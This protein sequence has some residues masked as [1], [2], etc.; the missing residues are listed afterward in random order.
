[1]AR[2]RRDESPGFHH[3]VSRGNN[4]RRIYDDDRDRAFFALHVTRIARA[5]GWRI[6][7]YC[8]MDN[9]YHLVIHVGDKGLSRGMCELNTG[10]AVYYNR[11]HGRV[12]HLFGKRYWNRR[13]KSEKSLLNVIRY[14]V[15]NP[16]RAGGRRELESYVWTSYPATVGRAFSRIE[17]ARDELLALFG[18]TPSSA[19]AAFRSFCAV[20]ASGEEPRWQPP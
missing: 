9:H 17:L 16:Q 10:Y 6:L 3:V 18:A 13:I 11:A 8:L 15:Q 20:T 14:V 19:L 2:A 12:N 4:K 5:H 7:A 1:M